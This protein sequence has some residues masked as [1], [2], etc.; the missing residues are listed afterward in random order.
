M[1]RRLST[2]RLAADAVDH[3]HLL[4]GEVAAGDEAAQVHLDQF[5]HADVVAEDVP[6]VGDLLAARNSR[7]GGMRSAS[8]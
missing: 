6:D 8:W 2:K 4:L 5:G 7:T 1:A 3:D